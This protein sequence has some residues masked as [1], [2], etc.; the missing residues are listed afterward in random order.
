MWPPL[1]ARYTTTAFP[2][3]LEPRSGLLSFTADDLAH[4]LFA[5]GRAPADRLRHGD[6]SL[7]EWVH[8]VALI[9]AYLE[10]EPK[11]GRVRRTGLALELDRSEKVALSYALGQAMTTVFTRQVLKVPYLMHVDRYAAR[12][13]VSF[14]NTARRADLF[15]LQPQPGQDWPGSAPGVPQATRPSAA[16][17][18][19]ASVPTAP[20][21]RCRNERRA[22]SLSAVA[23][24]APVRW[25]TG[26]R[27]RHRPGGRPPRLVRIRLRSAGTI[28]RRG[29]R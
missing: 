22:G 7:W 8:R 2:P 11:T 15:G 20:R 17:R 14:A 21:C 29:V 26:S 1:N 13:A 4:A 5:T 24:T 12:F 27:R 16:R 28:V 18:S 6:R 10:P 3:R 23:A 19:R 25:W 9:P